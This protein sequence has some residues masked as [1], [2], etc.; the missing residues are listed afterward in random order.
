MPALWQAAMHDLQRA[1]FGRIGQV[2]LWR[3]HD[4]AVLAQ[5]R[6]IA[7]NLG[8]SPRLHAHQH[9]PLPLA[10]HLAHLLR[11]G[12]SAPAVRCRGG[13]VRRER[14][15]VGVGSSASSVR[16]AKRACS[17]VASFE[18]TH[19]RR[20]D[21]WQQPGRVL[22]LTLQL[23]AQFLAQRHQLLHACAV[24]CAS[25]STRTPSSGR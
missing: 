25:L 1:G 23:V 20:Q 24:C 3:D 19:V 9:H 21:D 15:A 5:Q 7:K 4:D 22:A 10:E 2:Y 14:A 13:E 8:Q 11:E 16:P 6:L 17:G 12:A 18:A